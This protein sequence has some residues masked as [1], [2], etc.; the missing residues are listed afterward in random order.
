MTLSSFALYVLVGSAIFAIVHNNLTVIS[1]Y[2]RK[3]FLKAVGW[4]ER[5]GASAVTAA[6][7]ES[8][9]VLA[10]IGALFSRKAALAAAAPTPVAPAPPVV[11]PVAP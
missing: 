1:D 6:E 8:H 10:S 9:N 5:E 2:C 7:R 11:P 3:Q 4:T